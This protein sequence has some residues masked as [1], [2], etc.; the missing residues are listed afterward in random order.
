MAYEWT[1]AH[2]KIRSDCMRQ[3]KPWLKSTGPRTAEGKAKVAK[4]SWKGDARGTL[5][6][7]KALA[8]ICA[9]DRAALG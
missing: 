8:L 2:R 5:K 7:A 6:A 4:N 1:P 3:L 9:A